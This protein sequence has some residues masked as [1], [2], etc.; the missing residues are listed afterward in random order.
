MSDNTYIATI[1]YV[2][3]G[4]ISGY[5]FGRIVGA[6]IIETII[7]GSS[8]GCSIGLIKQYKRSTKI[9]KITDQDGKETIIK[10]GDNN[11]FLGKIIAA[12]FI[13]KLAV[14]ITILSGAAI[15]ATMIK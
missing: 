3:G 7:V 5:I 12:I 2:L 10:Y 4:C 6:N 1:G 9:E 8:I 14:P 15:V 11:N 13:W